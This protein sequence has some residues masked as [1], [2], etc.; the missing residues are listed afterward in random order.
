V[1]ALTPVIDRS[2]QAA[3]I[4]AMAAQA[5]ARP[6]PP[7]AARLHRL[8][9]LITEH[10]LPQAQLAISE[11]SVVVAV[12]EGLVESHVRR[13]AQALDLIVTEVPCDMPDGT[14]GTS[15]SASGW[16]G[17]GTW[18]MVEGRAPLAATGTYRL[19]EQDASA[20]NRA[21]ELPDQ[22][23]YGWTDLVAGPES[24]S[25]CGG[26]SVVTVCAND[27]SHG[28]SHTRDREYACTDCDGPAVA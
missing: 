10:D 15:W 20:L 22:P 11:R 7:F 3:R 4:A 28:C 25:T 26:S 14:A 21:V 17:R 5:A 18:W 19:T 6:L 2:A 13:W 1:K 23:N 9:A 24:C 16:D 27:G 12:H 8:A